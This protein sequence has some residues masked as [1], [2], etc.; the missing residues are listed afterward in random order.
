MRKEALWELKIDE[1]DRQICQKVKANLDHIAK[2]LDGLGVLEGMLCTLGAVQGSE[3]IRSGPRGLIVMCADNGIVAEG[4]SQSGQEVTLAVAQN[5]GNRRST[6]CKMASRADLEVIPV[7]IGINTA[8]K[9]PGVLDRKVRMGTRDFLKEPAMTE[10]EVLQAIETGI[11]LVKD[12][13]KRGLKI[14]AT[15]EMG[16]GNTT[17]STAVA[18]A[19]LGLR[20]PQITGRGAGL[21]DQGLCRKIQVIEEG[22]EKYGF[23]RNDRELLDAGTEHKEDGD[24]LADRTEQERAFRILQCVGGLDIAG[25]CGVFIGGSMYHIPVVIDGVI[26]AAAALCADRLVPGACRSMLASHAGAEPAMRYLLD[27]LDLREVIHADLA[28]GEG[29]GAV[30]LFPLLDMALE[31]YHGSSSFDEIGVAQYERHNT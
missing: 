26:S 30:M 16:I 11:D 14:L 25:L 7:D 23:H 8:Q 1:E 20:I 22:L 10:E 19:L 2:P 6:V 29:T 5:L 13:W 12:C 24:Q 28:L 4:V 15:G 31:V 27:A 3:I 17:T 18:A 9:I 21:S